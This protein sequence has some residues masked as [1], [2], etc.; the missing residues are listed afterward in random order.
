MRLRPSPYHRQRTPHIV[1]PPHSHRPIVLPRIP[2]T[3]VART[4]PPFGWVWPG[5]VGGRVLTRPTR[6]RPSA[7]AIATAW[8]RVVAPSFDMPL[9]RCV[10]TVA[11]E[12]KSALPISSLPRPW[13]SRRMISHSRSVSCAGLAGG[14]L[15]Q[16]AGDR[17]ID[18]RAASRRN[19]DGTYELVER[20]RLEHERLDAQ[21]HGPQQRRAVARAG[22][23]HGARARR[24]AAELLDHVEA[25]AVAEAQVDERHVR[26]SSRSTRTAS[27]TLPARPTTA[28]ASL[29]EGRSTAWA[30]AGWSSTISALSAQRLSGV[31]FSCSAPR[32][33]RCRRELKNLHHDGFAAGGR[34]SFGGSFGGR[35]ERLQ[36]TACFISAAI[37]CS[38][39]AVSSVSA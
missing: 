12:M 18:V 17:G 33:C 3:R 2:L 26:R 15:R 4:V 30:M 27:S 16:L 31:D 34:P 28:A 24:D 20:R 10:R 38:S 9:R 29:G 6:M 5:W 11:G 35:R 36:R 23:D 22:E 32:Q 13:A 21:I 14:R 19:G 25:V 37:F 7:Y 8:A 39:A 1:D